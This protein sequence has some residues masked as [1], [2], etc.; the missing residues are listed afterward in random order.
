MPFWKRLLQRT[1]TLFCIALGTLAVTSLW[2][3]YAG[4]TLGLTE[5]LVSFGGAFIAVALGCPDWPGGKTT[6][7]W[8]KPGGRPQK[9]H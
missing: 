2:Y 9:R 5:V 4:G 3:I 8:C 1:V 7:L 6:R